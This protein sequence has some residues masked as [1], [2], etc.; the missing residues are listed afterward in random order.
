MAG[1]TCRIVGAPRSRRDSAS[2][3][4]PTGGAG[5]WAHGRTTSGDTGRPSRSPRR[6]APRPRRPTPE[7]LQSAAS[8]CW[9]A[10]AS[11]R[12]CFQLK[13]YLS[14]AFHKSYY[15]A[16]FVSVPDLLRPRLGGALR[17]L[18]P[19]IQP[20]SGTHPLSGPVKCAV[21]SAGELMPES[22]HVKRCTVPWCTLTPRGE[23][24]LGSS[25]RAV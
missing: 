5:S 11:L 3:R 14:N 24:P 19:K 2:R 8:R 15:S 18:S 22:E 6:S 25:Q 1:L 9:T 16:V 17:F 12:S 7:K 21:R 13:L 20:S 4:R 23:E 10:S